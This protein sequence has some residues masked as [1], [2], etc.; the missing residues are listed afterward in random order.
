VPAGDAGALA[1]AL[2]D[3]IDAKALWPA[4]GEAGRAH[5]ARSFDSDVLTLRLVGIYR[6][7]LTDARLE[8]AR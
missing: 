6:S 8:S 3:L 1:A 5:V 7:L 4:L 2:G